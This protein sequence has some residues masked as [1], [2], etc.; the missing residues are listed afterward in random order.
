MPA[1]RAL[2]DMPAKRRR[3][4]GEY[5][6]EDLAMPPGQPRAGM[7]KRVPRSTDDVGH[8]QRRP[9]HLFEFGRFRVRRESR[10]MIQW[11]GDHAKMP[12]GHMKID[13][14]LLEVIVAQQQLNRAQ[15][16]SILQ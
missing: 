4:T 14:G 2:I 6:V 5:G 11:A 10:Q 12:L 15:V 1:P 8:L 3:P 9:L 16:G 13:A 7:E